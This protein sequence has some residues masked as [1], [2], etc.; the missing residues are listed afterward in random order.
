MARPLGAQDE[1]ERNGRPANTPRR[2]RGWPG[3]A[4]RESF[5]REGEGGREAEPRG[6]ADSEAFGPDTN[7]ARAARGVAAS[8][9]SSA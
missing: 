6:V 9:F 4:V 3:W 2:P 5:G 7:P 8:V 1:A